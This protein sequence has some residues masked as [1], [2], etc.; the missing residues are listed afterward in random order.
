[1]LGGCSADGST[2]SSEATLSQDTQL[3]DGSSK[4]EPAGEPSYRPFQFNILEALS[5]TGL[6]SIRYAREIPLLKRVVANDLSSSAVKAMK[7]NVALN[8]PASRPLEDWKPETATEEEAD[9]PESAAEVKLMEQDNQR[10]P[11]VVPSNDAGKEINPP[12]A[13]AEVT[14]AATSKNID[15]S[16]TAEEAATAEASI[17]PDCKIQ[18]NEGDALDV[19]Y[20]HRQP[21][22][23]YH[24]IDLDPYGTAAPFLDGAVQAVADGGLLCVTCTDLAVLASNGYPEKCYA[25]YGGSST[26][27][28]YSH[29]VA[30]R[31]VL[32]SIAM[33]ASRYGRYIKPLLSLSIDFYLRVF[34]QVQSAPIEVKKVASQQ[35]VVYT[36]TYCHN[37]HEQR[38]GRASEGVGRKGK[39]LTKY[40]TA[41][42]P[43]SAIGPGSSCEQCG[44]RYHVAGPMWLGPIHD[45]TFCNTLLG[46][47]ERSPERSR[48]APRIRGMVGTAASEL[49]D[50]PFY[51]TPGRVSGLMHSTSISLTHTVNALLNAGFKVSRSHCSAGSIKTD[52]SRG[53]IYDMWRS[54][55]TQ[56]HP[57]K[58]EGMSPN[59]PA[60]ALVLKSRSSVPAHHANGS[61]NGATVDIESATGD[62]G[63]ADGAA[64]AAERSSSSEVVWEFEKEH[65]DARKFFSNSSELG[66]T[67]GSAT[68]TGKA[69]R[70][71]QNPLPN[72][73]P[74]TAATMASK[75][76][77]Q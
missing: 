10:R 13:A 60:R 9:T 23:R 74:G 12:A 71:Q 43:P 39:P 21:Q 15:E 68:S 66:A 61:A 20:S 70:Y 30:L 63:V 54:W 35:G 53:Q 5:A 29:E 33:A 34:V 51:F 17:H 6:R 62:V 32:H 25:L 49:S 19:M 46:V 11:E 36:C 2:A 41:V 38:L 14:E 52:A 8:F 16:T 22:S 65:P 59:S 50:S 47:L 75:V 42:G 73:G 7:R 24:V 27:T 45:S 31:L 72:W 58:L 57:V 4:A 40:Q 44:S 76:K 69:V 48:T 28:E 26:R 3:A 55:I 56:G 64:A 67:G 18:I 1:M 77:S 37:F